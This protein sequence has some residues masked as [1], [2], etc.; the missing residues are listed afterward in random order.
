MGSGNC[1]VGSR[2]TT[3]KKKIGEGGKKQRQEGA[4][5]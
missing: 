4:K 2:E 5:E 3:Q 1:M